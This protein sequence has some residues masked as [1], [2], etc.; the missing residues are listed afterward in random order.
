M[1]EVSGIAVQSGRL[2]CADVAL[3]GLFALTLTTADID[4]VDPACTERCE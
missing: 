4:D 1:V 3:G 2:R